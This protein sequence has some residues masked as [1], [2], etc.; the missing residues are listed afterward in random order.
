MII[1]VLL[2]HSSSGVAKH[3]PPLRFKI[4]PHAFYGIK[5]R[6]C[7]RQVQQ[8]EANL[9]CVL[10][11]QLRFMNRMIIKN[12]VG[13]PWIFHEI[14]VANVLQEFDECFRQCLVRDLVLHQRPVLTDRSSN[15]SGL[16]SIFM[17]PHI[18]R[19]VP[20]HPYSGFLFPHVSRRFIS[21]NDLHAFLHETH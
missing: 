1:N 19:V 2:V 21:E 14:L 8:G 6:C 11:N 3:V 13:L 18:D 5:L 12:E 17:Q 9:C 16:S 4:C 7:R 10:L 20:R 15:G